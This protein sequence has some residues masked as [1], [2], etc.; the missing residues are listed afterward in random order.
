[1]PVVES[2]LLFTGG[3]IFAAFF[4]KAGN[5]LWNRSSDTGLLPAGNWITRRMTRKKMQAAASNRSHPEKVCT[6]PGL[7]YPALSAIRRWLAHADGQIDVIYGTRSCGKSSAAVI[8]VN[9]LDK[10]VPC[11]YVNLQ[12]SDGSTVRLDHESASVFKRLEVEFGIGWFVA[13]AELAA[14]SK[15]RVKLI[16]DGVD[17]DELTKIDIEGFYKFKELVHSE[18]CLD[19]LIITS[20]R[21]LAN[22]L[23]QLNGLEKICPWPDATPYP[24][25]QDFL[26]QKSSWLERRSVEW[27]ELYWPDEVLEAMIRSYCLTYSWSVAALDSTVIRTPVDVKRFCNVGNHIAPCPSA[28]KD[29]LVRLALNRETAR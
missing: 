14:Q 1:M 16:I 27:N 24:D 12:Q 11:I 25:I 9:G 19:V 15:R 21:P 7:E 20:S 17:G 23:T 4:Q 13:I 18:T 8:A 22:Q 28:T 6:I 10:N 5:A 26:R 3:A 29:A 2:F